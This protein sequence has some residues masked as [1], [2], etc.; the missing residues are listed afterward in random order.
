LSFLGEIKRRR[1]FQVAAVYAVVAWLIVQVVDVI[2][3]PL[4]L[5]AGF[6]TVVIVL[7]AVGFPVAL[8]L[9]WAFDLTPAGVV[10]TPAVEGPSTTPAVGRER[11][12]AGSSAGPATT[13]PAPGSGGAPR[14]ILR[15][16]V[17]VLPLEN[18]SPNPDDA[19]FAAGIHEEILNQLAKI[20]DL[21]VIART[22]V[23]KYR[24]TDK[25]IAEIA[26]ELGV[27]T[28]MEGSVRYAGERVRVSAQLIDAT[29]EN[30]LW[31]EVYERDLA[32]IFAIQA[33]I[34]TKIAAAL[35]AEL[36]ASEKQSVETLPTDSP[37]AY[38]L[39]LRALSIF[40]E[41]G[42]MVGSVHGPS[43][44]I[45]SS[46]DQAI[47]LD[48]RFALAYVARARL[49]ASRLNQD[50]GVYEDSAT[51][52]AELENRALRDVER[53]LALDP[54]IGI[55]HG[56]L[57]RIH[58]FNWRGA[59]AREA[60][61]RALELSP[62]EPDVLMDFAV[63]TA[64]S[65]HCREALELTERALR[66]DPNSGQVYGWLAF[67]NLFC[68]NLS[69]ALEA[70]R[71]G[72]ELTPTYTMGHMIV[73]AVEGMI[74]SR[75]EALR[76]TRLGE[77]LVR[78]YTNPAFFGTV[79]DSYARLGLGDDVERIYR[80]VQ[81]MAERGRVPATAW[82]WVYL[83]LGDEERALHYLK[84]AADNPESYVGHF[85]LMMIKANVFRSPMLDQPRFRA[86]RERLG[87]RD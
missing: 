84:A 23:R 8:V 53:A 34:A 63:F 4:S 76:E 47:E 15:N 54:G 64:M 36:S 42:H 45:Q 50:P 26:A 24:D 37:E 86:A 43:A 38:G 82:I 19:Y 73:A 10:R 28:V 62:N 3:D 61:R 67:T 14:E 44:T 35:E 51:R 1:V 71:H 72:M 75:A 17:A 77:H 56:L 74:G 85:G 48:P 69:A 21:S 80:H 60:Y 6:D 20:N 33:D 46:L 52:R 78:D 40:Q 7:V 12:E 59:E 79:A 18:L 29:T 49:S 22:S 81:G 66:L 16:S 2:N 83:A 55:A 39:Y 70:G 32:D 87:F 68:G 9:A 25:S 27:G 57:A 31:S 58:Q 11:E 41:R 30:H 5:P 65:G 13:I